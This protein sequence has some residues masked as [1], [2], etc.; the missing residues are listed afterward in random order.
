[1]TSDRPKGLIDLIGSVCDGRSDREDLR[2]LNDLLKTDPIAQEEYL[3]QMLIDGL[4]QQEFAGLRRTESQIHPDRQP[5]RVLSNRQ[6]LIAITIALVFVGATGW[7]WSRSVHPHDVDIDVA[8][9]NASFEE[10]A[11]VSY[12]PVSVGWYGDKSQVVRE[13][14]GVS[15]YHGEFML[16]L[17]Q[18]TSEPEESCEIY[19][20]VDLRN[21]TK[22]TRRHPV[23]LEAKVLVNSL[24][25][26]HSDSYVFSIKM[27][28]SSVN[29][30]DQQSPV[31]TDWKPSVFFVG[32]QV[33]AD[34]DHR[35][36]QQ[37]SSAMPLLSNAHFL[38]IQISVR[39][40]DR[41]VIERFPGHFVDNVTLKIKNHWTM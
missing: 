32:N 18:S 9:A 28:A 37:L 40:D 1:M 20:I 22:K 10:G 12:Q 36:W 34:T 16:K 38:L 17:D 39:R 5:R 30:L 41:K 29:P 21:V 15:P 35:S 26:E 33:T 27:Y 25:V 13:F 23:T 31:P 8:L 4:L 11:N 3:D 24:A 14:G 19:Q 7:L 6:L 2:Q